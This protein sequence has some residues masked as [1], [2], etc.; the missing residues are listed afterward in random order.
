MVTIELT[1][2]GKSRTLHITANNGHWTED[3]R[4]VPVVEGCVDV[5][6][7]WSPSTNMLPIRRLNLPVGGDSG[8]I[9]AAWV[10]FPDLAIE[11]LPQ[12]YQRLASDLYRY[13]SRNGEF[14]AEIRVDTHGVPIEYEGFWRRV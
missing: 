7:G 3:G 9:N 14:A 5:D 10:K 1:I 13:S 11:V 8:I 2:G 12:R 6:L 4:E